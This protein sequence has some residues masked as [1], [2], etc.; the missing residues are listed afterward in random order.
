MSL[1]LLIALFFIISPRWFDLTANY[2][3]AHLDGWNDLINIGAWATS[4]ALMGAAAFGLHTIASRTR[5][6]AFMPPLT[7]TAIFSMSV[8]LAHHIGWV[9][10]PLATVILSPIIF[11]PPLFYRA[12]SRDTPEGSLFSFQERNR[13][14]ESASNSLQIQAFLERYPNS[15][16]YLYKSAVPYSCGGLLLHNVETMPLSQTT[17]LEV[18]LDCPFT[19]TPGNLAPGRESFRAYFSRSVFKGSI[20]SIL[21]QTRWDDWLEGMQ[22]LDWLAII[23]EM[24]AMPVTHPFL[25]G[26]PYQLVER[27][28]A[29][30]RF[31]LQERPFGLN[32]IEKART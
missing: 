15:R 23:R 27:N 3:A 6:A 29:W 9:T 28:V 11:M 13:I 17:L 32:D 20:V 22:Y 14:R 26:I 30:N 12:I 1:I 8:F 5:S 16:A 24:D 4:S 7:A 25:D 18:T 19:T 2:A 31:A 21:P 10:I